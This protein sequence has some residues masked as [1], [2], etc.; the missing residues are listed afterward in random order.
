MDATTSNDSFADSGLKRSESH[1]VSNR[2]FS[3]ATFELIVCVR[4][5]M[6]G[7]TESVPFNETF[8]GV[9]PGRFFNGTF[10]RV[11]PKTQV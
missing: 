7:D 4:G 1:N 3:L 2:V 11:L 8:R 5:G 9:C 6:A 10:R